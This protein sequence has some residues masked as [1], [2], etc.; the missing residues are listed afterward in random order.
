MVLYVFAQTDTTNKTQYAFTIAD[1]STLQPVPFSTVLI[2]G[3]SNKKLIPSGFADTSG[4]FIVRLSKGQYIIKVTSIGYSNTEIKLNTEIELHNHRQI[5]IL[6]KPK[7]Y[8][9][10]G[11]QILSAKRI[12][13]AIPGGYKF[14]VNKIAGA[15]GNAIEILRRVPGIIVDGSGNLALMGKEPTVLVNGRRV[16]LS[17]ENL[18]VFLKSLS[19]TQ[20]KSVEVNNNPDAKY[21]AQ[22][23]GGILNIILK[24]HK[25]AGF[26]GNISSDISTL[27]STDENANINYK[28]GKF[29]FTGSFNSTYRQDVYKRTNYYENKTLPDSLYIFKQTLKSNQYQKGHS[30][31]ASVAYALDSTSSINLNFFS[32]FF[33]SGTPWIVNSNVFN[34]TNIFQSNFIQNENRDINNK[35]Y[36]YDLMYK[37]AF[38]NKSEL[39]VGFNYSKYDNLSNE[40]FERQFYDKSRNPT[41]NQYNQQ[42]NIITS[43]PYW[44][45]ASNIDYTHNVGK[46]TKINLGGKLSTASTESDFDNFVF[47]TTLAGKS[48]LKN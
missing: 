13:E 33:N 12:I 36:I 46:N 32:A 8:A 26:Y 38:K 35:F 28:K 6:L 31:R 14:N 5:R 30:F 24:D 42:L 40:L 48:L 29:D 16:N 4:N 2:Y 25:N 3:S 37:K 17:G 11:I 43:R 9:L 27:L 1:S 34:K 18:T 39:T 10:Q 44:V 20:I 19:A 41:L 45:T 47:D 22:G 23:E 21:D 7:P 15:T